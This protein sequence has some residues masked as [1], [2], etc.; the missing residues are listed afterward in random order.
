MNKL[1]EKHYVKIQFLLSCTGLKATLGQDEH[2]R[3]YLFFILQFNRGEKKARRKFEQYNVNRDLNRVIMSRIR[4]PFKKNQKINTLRMHNYVCVTKWSVSPV[5]SIL[6]DTHT[7]TKHTLDEYKTEQFGSFNFQI[8]F[9]WSTQ[10]DVAL[11][12]RNTIKRKRT[13]ELWL[14]LIHI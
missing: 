14:S 10:K 7:H 3:I 4:F 2:A 5:Q 1:I 8:A 12:A 11:V 13:E 6:E 9:G